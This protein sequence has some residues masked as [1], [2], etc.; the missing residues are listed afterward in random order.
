MR[1]EVWWLVLSAAAVG[2]AGAE[3]Q[4]R[5][6]A[7]HDFACQPA[8]LRIVDQ[9]RT[10]YR[11]AGCGSIATY[12]CDDLFPAHCK[13]AGWDRPDTQTVITGGG[14]YTL[15]RREVDDKPEPKA[16]AALGPSANATQPTTT[17]ASDTN[18]TAALNRADRAR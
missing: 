17:P 7:A 3:T 16:A 6:H 2:C 8:Q 9:E 14:S 15:T 11:V 4:V 13:R 12:Q 18:Q 5:K 1:R 10:V